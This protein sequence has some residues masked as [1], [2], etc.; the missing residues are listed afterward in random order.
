M[1]YPPWGANL[2]SILSIMAKKYDNF[3]SRN[4]LTFHL[5]QEGSWAASTTMATSGNS[6][7]ISTAN[8]TISAWGTSLTPI[9]EQSI[10]NCPVKSDR[11]LTTDHM[12][13][14]VMNCG[15]LY[16]QARFKPQRIYQNVIIPGYVR[17]GHEERYI[18]GRQL[19]KRK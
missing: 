4:W 19:N 13:Q 14:N 12:I 16:Q 11:K 3:E 1:G 7:S 5:G 10:H 17:V 15:L 18:F 8:S 2:H 9:Q 6:I